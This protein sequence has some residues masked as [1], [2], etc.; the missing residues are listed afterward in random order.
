[1]RIYAY[2]QD[3]L[4]VLVSIVIVGYSG[5]SATRLYSIRGILD[6]G[7]QVV[8]VI[9]NFF[10]A[11]PH[12]YV[13]LLTVMLYLTAFCLHGGLRRNFGA[14]VSFEGKSL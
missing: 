10:E 8:A 12:C 2:L 4:D 7:S 9:R 6:C 11:Y 3:R 14:L 1:M 5:D 13:A